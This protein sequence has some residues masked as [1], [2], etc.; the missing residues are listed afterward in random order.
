LI[1]GQVI[2][3]ALAA[4]KLMAPMPSNTGPALRPLTVMAVTFAGRNR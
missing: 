4:K 3:T 2:V 1:A